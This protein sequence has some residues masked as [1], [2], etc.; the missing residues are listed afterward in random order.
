MQAFT[1]SSVP[2]ETHGR[3]RRAVTARKEK[4]SV[5]QGRSSGS[6]QGA[7]NAVWYGAQAQAKAGIEV[8]G[9]GA[10]WQELP[11]D[12]QPP[13]PRQ[14]RWHRSAEEGAARMEG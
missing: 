9:R 6:R 7:G 11:P 4:E 5:R 10:T 1:S 3:E 2:E 13:D 14:Y 8:S 12:A